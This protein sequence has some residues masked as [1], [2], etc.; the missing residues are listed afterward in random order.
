MLTRKQTYSKIIYNN[1]D[2]ALMEV[3]MNVREGEFCRRVRSATPTEQPD[4][5]RLSVSDG[6]AIRGGVM[7][8]SLT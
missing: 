3:K 2:K 1:A 6:M 4:V 7:Q 8:G 5:Y